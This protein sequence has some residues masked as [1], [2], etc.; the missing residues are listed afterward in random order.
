MLKGFGISGFRS[1][2][3]RP[4]YLAPL[5]KVNIL[6]G[7]NNAGKS[8]ILLAL[9]RMQTFSAQRGRDS[10]KAFDVLLDFHKGKTSATPRWHFPFFI[11]D[12]SIAAYVKD[13]V[14]DGAQRDLGKGWLRSV[15]NQL[16][17]GPHG[18]VWFPFDVIDQGKLVF[19]EA[20]RIAA[21]VNE[22]QVRQAQTAWTML[23]SQSTGQTG[24]SLRQHHVPELLK[25]LA[26]QAVPANVRVYQVGPHRQVGQPGSEYEGLNGQGLIAHLLA[27][28]HPELNRRADLQRFERINQFVRSVVGA[29]DARL[30][31][32]HS[33]KELLVELDGRLLPI[34]SLGTGIQQVIVLAAAATSVDDSVVCIEEPEVHLHPRLQRKLLAYLQ[35]QTTNQ[36]FITT[37]SASLLDAEGVAIF[38]V[39]LDEDGATEVER[40][41]VPGM[42][43]AVTS[44]LGYRASDLVQAN[45]VVWVEGPSDRIYVSAWLKVVAPELVEGL[46]FSIMFYGGR[47]L[48][49]LTADDSTVNEFISLQRLN[50]HVAIVFDSDKRNAKARLNGTKQRIIDEIERT[51]GFSWVTRG[52][53]I[54]NY[55]GAP[56]ILAAL[57]AQHPRLSFTAAADEFSKCYD[58]TDGDSSSVDKIAL[59]L[60]VTQDPDL[61]ILDLRKKVEALAEFIR[62]ANR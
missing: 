4:Q 42:R 58:P 56:A 28:Q 6:A 19:P 23:W 5:E 48:S 43:T 34:Q 16:T 46:H 44:D 20:E 8:N 41:S 22:S 49:H 29:E 50:R 12:A 38:H 54:E 27:L 39:R 32:P 61:S 53:E 59:A 40:L 45:S 11:D 3:N 57:S 17:A 60:R 52:R 10:A 13:L 36:Y 9:Q 35:D 26:G 31:V 51:G 37:H 21:S 25:R 30:E 7:K 2:G 33:G 15:L 1:F 18:A 62:K 47:L 55:V 14:S 24:G